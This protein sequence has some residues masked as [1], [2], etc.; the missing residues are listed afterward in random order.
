MTISADE[1]YNDV[2]KENS[3]TALS[4]VKTAICNSGVPPED[5]ERIVSVMQGKT[6]RKGLKRR[7]VGR[8]KSINVAA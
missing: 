1:L 2:Q 8:T 7:T 6:N 5:A 3:N 4:N